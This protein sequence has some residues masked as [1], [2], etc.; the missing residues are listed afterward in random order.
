MI[1][2][3]NGVGCNLSDPHEEIRFKKSEIKSLDQFPSAQDS[4]GVTVDTP[5]RRKTLA[6]RLFHIVLWAIIIVILL[7]GLIFS[8]LKVGISGKYLTQKM[9]ATLTQQLG[10]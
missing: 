8:L 4:D 2:E 1:A 10:D 3:I 5:R 7:L 9:Q 6:R